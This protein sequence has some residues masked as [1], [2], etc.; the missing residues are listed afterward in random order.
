MFRKKLEKLKI[1]LKG[2]NGGKFSFDTKTI[3]YTEGYGFCF[4]KHFVVN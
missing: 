3:A 1:S 4:F 2:E